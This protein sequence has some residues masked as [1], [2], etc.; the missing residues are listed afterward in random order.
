[1]YNDSNL[2]IDGES[3]KGWIQL[4]SGWLTPLIQPIGRY[5]SQSYIKCV[6]CS[7]IISKFGGPQANAFC[8]N[9]SKGK[10]VRKK[11]Q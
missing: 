3:I 2:K 10:R 9:C 5:Y 11:K 1:V 6:K 4:D 8:L 7:V